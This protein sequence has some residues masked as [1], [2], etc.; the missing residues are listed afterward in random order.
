[1]SLAQEPPEKNN[2]LKELDNVILT[3]HIGGLTL[4]CGI[5]VSVLAAQAVIDVL[6]GK[7]PNGVVNPEVP[8][9]TPLARSP[10]RRIAQ[11]VFSPRIRSIGRD[12]AGRISPGKPGFTLRKRQGLSSVALYGLRQRYDKEILGWLV[13]SL[14]A[15]RYALCAMRFSI[16]GRLKFP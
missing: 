5:K 1:M 13:Q 14:N 6:Q 16:S 9:A 8:L 3:P 11:S 10:K 2:P 15:L 7:K 12:Q 4:E